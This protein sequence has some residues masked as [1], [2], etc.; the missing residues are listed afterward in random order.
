[1]YRLIVIFF[2][3][4]LVLNAQDKLFFSNGNKRVGVLVN[5]TQDAVFFKNS[6]TAL[7]EKINKS[8]L[9][10]V[11][12]YKGIRYIFSTKTKKLDSLPVMPMSFKR[13]SF[14]VQP[15]DIF[16]GRATFVYERFTEDHKIGFVVPV[17]ITFDPFG[18]LYKSA[19][20]TNRTSARRVNG[21]NV[22]AGLDVNF[23]LG[24][25]ERRQF[26][27]GPRFRYGTDQF[28]RGIEG[29]SLQTQF[30]WKY[31][32]P[33]SFFVQHFSLGFGFIRI[34][35]SPGNR[36]VDSKQS[37]GWYSINYRVGIKW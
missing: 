9:L 20:D 22:I 23:Y 34:L 26:F 12:D 11:E 17:S 15:W 14:G 6:D 37:Y 4:S 28:L 19:I 36:L 1:M 8:D 33:A 24:K 29:Y 35:S 10:L 25:K 16:V 31:E 32:K 3:F 21:V 27:V 13:N 30:G 5:M 7:V 2:L 18:T